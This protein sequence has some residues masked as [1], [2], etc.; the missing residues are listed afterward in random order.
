METLDLTLPTPPT[1]EKAPLHDNS[2]NFELKTIV[3]R[4]ESTFQPNYSG[5]YF[6]RP[7]SH[8]TAIDDVLDMGTIDPST[9]SFRLPIKELVLK[10]CGFDEEIQD[11]QVLLGRMAP[12]EALRIRLESNW[13]ASGVI[14]VIPGEELLQAVAQHRESLVGLDLGYS[15]LRG[16]S[17]SP[18]DWTLSTFAQL[19]TLTIEQGL[20]SRHWLQ[21]LPRTIKTLKIRNCQC[22]GESIFL[23]TLRVLAECREAQFQ[24]LQ[25]VVFEMDRPALTL[26]SVEIGPARTMRRF[27]RYK[28]DPLVLEIESVLDPMVTN[29][30]EDSARV[31]ACFHGE[32]L[33]LSFWCAS[34]KELEEGWKYLPVMQ[35][36]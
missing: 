26:E 29:S 14:G 34:S 7:E 10:S 25:L 35:E 16:G 8:I 32:I 11:L 20:V 3:I 1:I 9:D 33:G 19:Q 2:A 18:L 27:H 5:R 6:S 22:L 12:L 28:L 4:S 13:P 30:L 31:T 36:L 24:D 15:S 21:C 17:D 23:G